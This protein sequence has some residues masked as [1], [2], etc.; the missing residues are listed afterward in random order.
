MTK[1]RIYSSLRFFFF[2]DVL[3]AFGAETNLQLVKKKYVDIHFIILLKEIDPP[4][5]Y[6]L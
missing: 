1:L 3:V 6:K 5:M 2:A 4:K